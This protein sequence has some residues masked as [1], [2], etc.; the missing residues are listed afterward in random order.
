MFAVR[1]APPDWRASLIMASI[2]S[3]SSPPPEDTEKASLAGHFLGQSDR[4]RRELGFWIFQTLFWASIGIVGLLATHAFRAAI[5]GAELVILLRMV[6]GFAETLILRWLFRRPFLQNKKSLMKWPLAFGCCAVVAVIEAVLMQATVAAGLW[7]TDGVE[8]VGVRLLVVRFFILAI[9][10]CLYFGFQLLENVHAMELRLTR[11]ELAAR[12]YELRHLQS[13]MNPHFIFSAL[14]TVMSSKNNPAAVQEVTEALSEYLRFLL[15]EAR[16]L[17][18]LSREIDALERYLTIQGPHLWEKL[19]CRIQCENAARAVMV[20][21]MMIQPLLEDAFRHR[22]QINQLPLQI[23]VTARIEKTFLLVNVS[24]T[25]EPSWN[26]S[27]PERSGLQAL[28][29]R[30][31]LLLGSEV[32]VEQQDD[33]GWHRVIVHVPLTRTEAE[34]DR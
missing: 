32:R 30:L 12:E 11:A 34:Q 26:G 24:S 2:P 22:R 21:P 10:T 28:D 9:W 13:R 7:P 23:W 14:N 1:S 17:E 29:Y 5:P 8:S 16:P 27:P 33:S 6:I 18:P 4:K 3:A 31:R 20:P 15:K 25:M 19:V